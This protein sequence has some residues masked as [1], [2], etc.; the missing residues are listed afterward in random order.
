MKWGFDFDEE[1]DTL[2]VYNPDKN[3]VGAVEVGN[4]VFD[5]DENRDL[6]AVEILD[7]SEVLSKLI[8]KMIELNKI[9]EI[10]TRIINFRNMEAIQFM[11]KSN[12]QVEIANVII[13]RIKDKSPALDY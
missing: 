4:F 11:I 2:F 6:T 7:A 13:P 3:S 8:T 10:R 5:F 12:E 9:N 1:N